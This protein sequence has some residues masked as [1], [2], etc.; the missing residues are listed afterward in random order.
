MVRRDADYERTLAKAVYR[1]L[2]D[3]AGAAGATAGEIAAALD[4]NVNMKG[5]GIDGR[6]QVFMSMNWLRAHGVDVVCARAG[7]LESP[8][9][10]ALRSLLPESWDALL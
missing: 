6:A 9:R 5:Q 4:W 2:R 7:D 1:Y 8:S 3:S 10:W